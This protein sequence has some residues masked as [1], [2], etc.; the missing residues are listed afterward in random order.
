MEV[1]AVHTLCSLNG[2]EPSETKHR[3]VSV[4]R[5][6]FSLVHRPPVTHG[7]FCHVISS[8][9][10]RDGI[11]DTPTTLHNKLDLCTPN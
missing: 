11:C 7:L 6:E 8:H 3:N 10:T 5:N 1:A 9:S 4:L 2:C